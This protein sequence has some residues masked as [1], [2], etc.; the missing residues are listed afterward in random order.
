MAYSLTTNASTQKITL[1]SSGSYTGSIYRPSFM[2]S[3][4]IVL[5]ERLFHLCGLEIAVFKHPTFFHVDY[6]NGEIVVT[7][8]RGNVRSRVITQVPGHENFSPYLQG[9]YIMNDNMNI[10]VL[11]AVLFNLLDFLKQLW[12]YL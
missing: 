2:L 3:K 9:V 10:A 1:S 11:D 12:K 5:D 7:S 4:V 8:P 6:M